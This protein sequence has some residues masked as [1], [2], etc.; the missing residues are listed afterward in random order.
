ML[1][2]KGIICLNQVFCR[3]LTSLP[4]VEPNAPIMHTP[5]P[6]PESKKLREQ[7]ETVHQAT[8]VKFFANYEKSFGNYLVDA[9]DNSLLDVY[10]QISSLPLGYNHP[11]L[12]E[13]AKETRFLTCSVSRPA[14]GGY[15]R[16]DFVQSLK[17]SLG[18]VAPP[19]LVH[20]QAMLCGTSANENAIKT[21]FIH[22]Q[23]R[24]RGGNIP[25]KEDMD[26]CMNNELPGTPNLSVLGFNGSFHGRS[27]GMLSLTRS[28][29]I[30]KVDIPA[31]KWP[32]AN[33]PRYLYPLEEN[34][35]YND[36]QD[37]KCLDEVVE[38]IEAGKREGTEVAAVIVEPI[39]CEG[40]D[41][42]ASPAFFS[43]VFKKFAKIKK[44]IL[45]WMK[46]RQEVEFVELFGHM[47][48]G[49]C[50]LHQILLHSQKSYYLV[51]I[52]IK[53]N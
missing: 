45:L 19:G 34:K 11:E 30:H 28:K 37:K 2:K 48:S 36:E 40:G 24:K 38:L 13:L 41:N 17:N 16:T 39:Q 4:T 3:H 6:G 53:M 10:T 31:F 1:S 50:L 42:H 18:K 33:F 32:S 47:N 44:F 7:M 14:L 12:I 21:A 22:Y 52:I 51:V 27:L 15:P 26:S 46:Y 20:V 43:A 29:A 25:T 23:T 49:D 5:V 8:S 35:K 9:D